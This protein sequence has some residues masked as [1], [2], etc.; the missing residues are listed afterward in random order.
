M[1]A[2]LSIGDFARSTN[3][4]VKTLRFYHESGLLAPNEIDPNSGYRRYDS[5]QIPT[6]Q[7]IRRFRELDMGLDTIR[8]IISTTDIAERNNLITEH[9]SRVELDLERTR[10]VVASLHDLVEHPDAEIPIEHRSIDA[11]PS[12]TISAV[13]GVQDAVAWYQGAL[14]EIFASLGAQRLAPAG[15]AGAIWSNEIFTDE[16]GAA[17]IFV[18]C[19]GEVLSIGRVVPLLVPGTELAVTTHAGP[20]DGIDRAYGA[21]GSY[22]AKHALAV[23]GPIREYFIVGPHETTNESEWRTEIGWPVFATAE[24]ARVP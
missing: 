20:L 8:S 22:V 14:A 7:V 4:S 15:T 11:T 16:L 19:R 2:S 1:S 18:P 13:V 12:A 23:D 6:A 24:P 17:T 21:L 5:E 9:L 10:A 3:L